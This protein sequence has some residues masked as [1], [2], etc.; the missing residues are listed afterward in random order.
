MKPIY[1]QL[2]PKPSP[3]NSPH[4]LNLSPFPCRFKFQILIWLSFKTRSIRAAMEQRSDIV[5]VVFKTV[6]KLYP[7]ISLDSP[8]LASIFGVV[9][10]ESGTKFLSDSSNL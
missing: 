4:L 3:P 10:T 5:I 1:Q 6:L 7:P 2:N 8:N 9:S